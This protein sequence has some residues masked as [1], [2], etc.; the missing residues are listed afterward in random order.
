MG[1]RIYERGFRKV[2][3]LGDKFRKDGYNA[4]VKGLKVWV[5]FAT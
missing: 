5:R 1:L 3:H 4:G 2:S